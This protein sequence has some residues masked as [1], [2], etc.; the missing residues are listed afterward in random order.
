MSVA[1][2]KKKEKI[3]SAAMIMFA[4]KGF[5][6]SSMA[7][8]A[9]EAGIGKGTT[10]EYFK[11]K[12]DLFFATFQWYLKQCENAANVNISNIAVKKAE[13]K[14]RA[15]SQAIL[16]ALIEAK[17]LY[18][19]VFEFW[20]ATGSSKYQNEMKSLFKNLYKGLSSVL[21][22]IIHEGVEIG[23]FEF[24]IDIDSFVPAV[25]G[26]WDAI[27]LQNWFDDDFKME[28]AING[29]TDLVIRG[30]KKR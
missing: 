24:D 17:D 18:P 4:K 10:Y 2:E 30:L 22:D 9:K 8:I 12:D 25:V 19:L 26:A 16:N 3:I 5:A 13:D 20:A 28:R 1:Q 27:G 15:F 6:K 14:I 21:S 7:D 29:F 11:G 23:E